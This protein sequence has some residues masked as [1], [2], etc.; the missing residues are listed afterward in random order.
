MWILAGNS[1]QLSYTDVHAV[2][3]VRNGQT[4]S[5]QSL[6]LKRRTMRNRL[7]AQ[8]VSLRRQRG[9]SVG[10]YLFL[11]LWVFPILWAV[12]YDTEFI[13]NTD[14]PSAQAFCHWRFKCGSVY[15]GIIWPR[16][17]RTVSTLNTHVKLDLGFLRFMLHVN[18]LLRCTR[19]DLGCM[20]SLC[21][22]Q[23]VP[24]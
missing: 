12:E 15:P 19:G 18:N 24:L 6:H 5:S 11:C 3:T 21:Q 10:G 20:H 17:S 13:I 1:Y 4:D 14:S 2:T 23:I 16:K 9:C 7:W 8:T 22:Y